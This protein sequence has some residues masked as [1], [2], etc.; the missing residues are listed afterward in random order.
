MF[1]RFF[2][3]AT[4]IARR[5][6]PPPKPNESDWM[7]IFVA[8]A[9]LIAVLWITSAGLAITVSMATRP[10]T[11]GLF[12]DAFGSVNALFSG[13][14]LAGVIVALMMQQDELKL[15]RSELQ[16]TREV[17]SA[18]QG[19]LERSAV[20]A[21]QAN[22]LRVLE[23]LASSAPPKFVSQIRDE[24]MYVVNKGASVADVGWAILYATDTEEGPAP[25]FKFK[26]RAVAE[27]RQIGFS[28]ASRTRQSRSAQSRALTL[29]S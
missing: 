20:Q 22:R 16:H 17:L 29:R 6:S 27:V 7:A 9:G 28:S 23:M 18:Q 14:A 15:Q 4:R 12:G 24:V 25:F 19:E 1:S 26:P 21:E 2:G 8:G 5:F 3:L 13:L 11:P 10:E